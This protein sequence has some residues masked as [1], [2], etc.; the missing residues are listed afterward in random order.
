MLEYAASRRQIA[1]RPSSPHA[2]LVIISVHVA[3]LAVVISAKMDLPVPFHNKP[4][5]VTFPHEPTPPPPQP[6]KTP[7][8][9]PHLIPNP[10]PLPNVPTGPIVQPTIETNPSSDFGNILGP[11]SN[12]IPTLQPPVTTPVRHQAQLLTPPWELKPPYPATKL[13]SEEEA[14]L[15]LRLTIDDRGRVIAVDPVGSAD[16]TFLDAAR[17]YIIAHW[18]YAAATQDGRAVASN[19]TITLRFEL[20]G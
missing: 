9:R 16:R 2:M 4:I 3:L 11:E 5:I 14:T 19:L 20:D 10:Q 17:R 1:S 15:T 6:I 13:A 7:S 12:P 8:P 18:R